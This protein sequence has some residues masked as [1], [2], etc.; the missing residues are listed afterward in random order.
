MKRVYSVENLAIAW[1]MKNL[2]ISNGIEAIVKNENLY[3]VAGELPITECMP[4]VWVLDAGQFEEAEALIKT[5]DAKS[6]NADAV[7]WACD[8]CGE[9]NG[10]A[11]ELCWKC[12]AAVICPS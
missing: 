3:S 9:S 10:A 8:A 12:Q 5:V 2:L 4:E 7:D 6:R 11:F 1:H